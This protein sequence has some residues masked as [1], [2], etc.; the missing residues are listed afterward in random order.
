MIYTDV[1]VTRHSSSG[2]GGGGGGGG[3]GEGRMGEE[4]TVKESCQVNKRCQLFL[5]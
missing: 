3:L 1:S 2:E 5:P 4:V